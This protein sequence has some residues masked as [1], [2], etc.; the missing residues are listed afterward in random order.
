MKTEPRF[1]FLVFCILVLAFCSGAENPAVE[2]AHTH[3][4]ED[5]GQAAHTHEG[6]EAALSHEADEGA[7]PAEGEHAHR[8]LDVTRERQKAWGIRADHI[9]KESLTARVSLPGVLAL[10]QNRTAHVSAFVHGQIATLS[11]DLGRRVRKGQRLLTLNSPDFA[12]LQADFL[13]ARAAYNLSRAEYQRAKSLWEARAIEEK[14]YLRRQAEHEKLSTEYGALGSKLHSLGLTHDQIDELIAKCRLVEELE[15]KCEV[16]DP[17]LPLLAPLSG[18]VIFRDA[19]QGAHI[20]P[21]QI[22]LTI[23]DLGSLWAQLDVYEMDIPLVTP[24][25]RVSIR[26]DLYP[27][28]EFPARITYISNLV[29]EKLRTMKVRVEVENPQGLL[30]PNMFIQGVLES[31]IRGGEKVLAVPEE[32]VQSLDG[33]KIV[34]VREAAEVFAVRHVTIGALVDGHRIILSGLTERENVVLTGA[35]T[36]K[37]ELSKGT[38]GHA[39]VH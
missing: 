7:A 38:F 37:S 21:E 4:G 32:A 17:H 13:Q 2:T 6:E 35:F 25:S 9:H 33:E 26:S 31:E 30:K 36:L 29:D 11:V 39:H 12:E 22:L 34:F 16:A 27:D 8:H 19:V 23:S 3:E 18:T 15:Y 10:N 28:R 5:P 1:I 20:E 24:E 14:E